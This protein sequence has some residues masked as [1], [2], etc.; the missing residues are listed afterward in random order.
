MPLLMLFGAGKSSPLKPDP[1][2]VYAGGDFRPKR[3]REKIIVTVDF[4]V[5]LADGE[6]IKSAVWEV[7]DSSGKNS[8]SAMVSGRPTIGGP[9]VSQMI[10][11][12]VVDTGC[13]PICY[14]TTSQ[15]QILTLPRPG[16]G[17]MRIVD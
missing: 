6:T 2:W 10:V 11:N 7:M 17:M 5:L 1:W 15:R 9:L 3:A 12:G 14:A 4:S 16:L 13:Y 8:V